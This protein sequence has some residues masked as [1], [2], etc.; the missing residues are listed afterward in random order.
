MLTIFTISDLLFFFVF[1]ASSNGSHVT[2]LVNHVVSIMAEGSAASDGSELTPQ[3]LTGDPGEAGKACGGGGSGVGGG[4]GVAGK[5]E[6]AKHEPTPA[7]S[8]KKVL[9][10]NCHVNNRLTFDPSVRTSIG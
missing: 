10:M 8:S 9:C 3:L 1:L 5:P 4:G 6:A 7:K 2:T